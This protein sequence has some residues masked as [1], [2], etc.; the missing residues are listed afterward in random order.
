MMIKSLYKALAGTLYL[1][2]SAGQRQLR[3]SAT[4]LML[5]RVLPDE[6]AAGMPHRQA[7]CI[8]Q[9]S[10]DHLL[11]WL[12]RHFDC[13]PL[14]TLLDEPTGKRPRIALTFDDGWRDNALYALPLLQ[15]HGVPASIFLSTDFIGTHQ[16]FWWESIGETLWAYPQSDISQPLRQQLA[17]LPP[18]DRLLYADQSHARSL[19]L[20]SYLQQLKRLTPEQ[21]Q[22]LADLCP[23]PTQPHAMDWQQVVQLEQSGLIRFGPHGAS[24]AILPRLAQQQLE[25]D[26]QRSHRALHHYCVAPLPVYCYPNGDHNASVRDAVARLGYRHALSTA[27]GLI[28]KDSQPLALPRID[29]SHNAARTPSML[30]WRLYRGARA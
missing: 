3:Q 4:I 25:E 1:H 15:Q 30:A 29:L 14:E 21:L 28:S 6:Q 11:Y 22:S 23:E 19:C 20:A 7:L 27:P 9:Q 24:H 8:G 12:R 17:Q 26:L 5:H 10:F 2:S 18:P 16:R 13:L